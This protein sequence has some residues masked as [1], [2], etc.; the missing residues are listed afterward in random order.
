MLSEKEMNDLINGIFNGSITEYNLPDNLY[1]AIADHLKK[2]V[3]KGFGIDF[4]KLSK[5]ESIKFDA[6][7]LELLTELRENVYMFSAAK[8]FNEV[9]DFKG[10]LVNENGDIKSFKEFK[11][12]MFSLDEQYNKN[13]L[14]T[15][16][17]TAY[18]QA[19]NAVAWNEFEKN[20]DVLPNLRYSAVVD[21][22]TSDICAPLD[23]IV[24]P[25]DDPFWNTFMPLNHFNC[26]CLVTQEDETVMVTSESE[27]KELT[28]TPSEEMQD[29]FKMNSG[30][31]GVVFSEKHPYFD[32]DK[33]YKELAE[34]NFNLPIP[35][36]D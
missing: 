29:A 30:K 4:D 3:Y 16:Y 35:E 2:G 17:D 19:Q 15:E 25:I 6:K 14:R 11:Q 1:F 33:K 12:D 34:N 31:K 7:D 36:N 32:V 28:K 10:A 26:R 23:G 5:G 18:G 22:N 24:L 21:E 20:K 9:L 8:T 27:V 13:W